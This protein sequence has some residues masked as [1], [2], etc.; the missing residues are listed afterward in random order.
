M[1]PQSV[2][3]P[4]VRALTTHLLASADTFPHPFTANELTSAVFTITKMAIIALLDVRNTPINRQSLL[5]ACAQ[6][7]QEVWSRAPKTDTN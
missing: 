2:S 1:H 5:N 6:L 3:E 4:T 7:E